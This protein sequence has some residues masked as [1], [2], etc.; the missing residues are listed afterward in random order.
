MGF[1]VCGMMCRF[2]VMRYRSLILLIHLISAQPDV[3]LDQFILDRMNSGY[4]PGLSA[5]AIINDQVV[6]TNSYGFANLTFNISVTDDTNFLLASI[7]KLVTTTAIM[8]I[9]ENGD[10]AL[11]DN[12]NQYLP[13]SVIN[14]SYPETEITLYM[15]LTHTSSIKED[16]TFSE[17]YSIFENNPEM[18]LEY[19]LSNYLTPEGEFYSSNNFYNNEPGE[20]WQYSNIGF[21]L[22]ALLVENITSQTFEEYCDI[23]IFNPLGMVETSWHFDDMNELNV[24]MPYEWMPGWEELGH[25]FIPYYPSAQ[26]RSNV[27]ELSY[28]LKAYMG[29]M[30]GLLNEQLLNEETIE[31]ILFEHINDGWSWNNMSE[32]W[33]LGWYHKIINGKDFWGHNGEM[34]GV[35]TEMFFNKEDK[36]G[37]IILTNGGD[38]YGSWYN[39]V[40]AVED[41]ILNY[42]YKHISTTGDIN[43]DGQINYS[44]MDIIIDYLFG[45]I[46]LSELQ[47]TNADLDYNQII[48]IFDALL[49][50][51]IFDN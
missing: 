12:I 21:A 44:D 22:I 7:S 3:D 23:N 24:A 28:F 6:W 29:Y 10:I 11:N 41:S 40:M 43:F 13:F 5:C 4:I 51:D 18:E 16:L 37:I 20:D 26:L 17:E 34:W 8:Q 49:I 19:F 35:L 33:G 15:L 31:L 47:T 38:Y 9:V 30:P 25:Y 14:P 45:N 36:V 48:D 50:I 1:F 42:V 27:S 39:D 32:G 2:I 46:I